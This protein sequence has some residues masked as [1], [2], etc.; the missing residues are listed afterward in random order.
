MGPKSRRRLVVLF[1]GVGVLYA[2]VHLPA[3][4]RLALSLALR[5]VEAASG[6]RARAESLDY[7]LAGLDFRVRGLVLEAPGR[8]P[9]VE[10][11]EARARLG[12]ST[13]WA[14][15]DLRRVEATG[16]RL[17]LVKDASGAW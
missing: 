16:V 14:H 11:E 10:V 6:L 12:T 4:R 7:Q 8:E 2:L 15:P 5:R 13:L 1:A 17:H 3:V 9:L